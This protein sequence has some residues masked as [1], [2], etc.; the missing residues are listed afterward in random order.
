MGGFIER[1]VGLFKK[2]SNTIIG[3]HHLSFEE[4]RT[5]VKSA[6]ATINSR[7][8]TYLCQGL[9]EGIPLT[10]SMIMH[11]HNL[12]D[13]PSHSL[14]GRDATPDRSSK[15]DDQLTLEQR[16]HMLENIKDSFWNRWSSQYLTEL[17]ERHVRQAKNHPSVTKFPKVGDVCL[18]KREKTP[19]RHWPLA[20]V[21]N[22]VEKSEQFH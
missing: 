10:P 22:V 14:R 16:Y 3:A 7:P 12:T 18:L 11:G 19:R 15:R 5:F 9:E 20:I 13:L 8:L 4:F 21:E 1:I 17:Q 6:Q 2:I